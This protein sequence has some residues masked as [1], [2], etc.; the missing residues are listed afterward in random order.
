VRRTTVI[1][2][3]EQYRTRDLAEAA[4]N[5][6]RMQISEHRLRQ[7]GPDILV[8]DLVDDYVQTEL[9]EEIGWHSHATRIVHRGFLT[10]WI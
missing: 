3:V 9:S 4:V 2:T 8:A 5:G 6:L 7:P 10:R 1:E